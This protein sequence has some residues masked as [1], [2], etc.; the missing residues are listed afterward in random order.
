MASIPQ[1]TES[2]IL[3]S[4]E[5]SEQMGRR[6]YTRP[7]LHLSEGARPCWFFRPSIPVRL[8]PGVVKSRQIKVWVEPSYNARGKL[9]SQRLAEKWRDEYLV[10]VNRTSTVVK[11]QMPFSEVIEMYRKV[12][13]PELAPNT[14]ESYERVIDQL[15][16]PHFGKFALCQIGPL[17]VEA[18][19][20][21]IQGT[22]HTRRQRLNILSSILECAGRWRYTTE[23][24]P[25]LGI[26]VKG[27]RPPWEHKSLEPIQIS[28]FLAAA[29]E[30]ILAIAEIAT[31]CG[32]R[33]GEI[34]ALQPRDI[35]PPYLRIR[36]TMSQ[37]TDE[38]KD[39]PKNEKPRDLPLPEWIEKKLAL[40][41]QGLRPDQLIFDLT[42]EQIIGRMRRLAKKLD[43][44]FRGFG[45]HTLRSSYA[46]L[47]S[48][49]GGHG[50]QE[51][52]GHS[53]AAM[54]AHYIRPSVQ[55]KLAEIERMR[56]LIYFDGA[57]KV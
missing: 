28:R 17:E 2:D 29:E 57:R 11:A 20:G 37:K 16:E 15:I 43:I 19:L 38:L 25:R 42:Y 50:L 51:D 7:D 18:W 34:R 52:M 14:R 12:H 8:A 41:S 54:T 22:K 27:N 40:I 21:T 6:F 35:Q 45:P 56:D 49:Q 9:I 32:A 33:V 44:W 10:T 3:R 36:R 30:P 24:N 26:K 48:E 39:Y 4:K 47:R 13:L 53:S 46:T 23:R 5:V 55:R 1:F 31:F